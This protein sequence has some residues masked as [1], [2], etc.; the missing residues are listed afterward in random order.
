MT[1]DKS[2]KIR[3]PWSCSKTTSKNI[4]FVKSKAFAHNILYFLF[5]FLFSVDKE[6]RKGHKWPT[7]GRSLWRQSGK[8]RNLNPLP[9]HIHPNNTSLD[10]KLTK[11]E[12]FIINPH[13]RMR[14]SNDLQSKKPFNLSGNSLIR[15]LISLSGSPFRLEAISLDKYQNYMEFQW[16][17]AKTVLD[18]TLILFA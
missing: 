12:K 4:Y 9:R 7:E 3:P 5:F 8:I 11:R 18:V 15:L 16:E 14:R 2:L 1:C 10:E 6:E 13:K 17:P